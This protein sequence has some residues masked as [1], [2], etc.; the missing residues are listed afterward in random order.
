VPSEIGT[1]AHLTQLFLQS[2]RLQG[3]LP[4][5]IGAVGAAS[6][7]KKDSASRSYPYTTS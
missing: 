7:S 4:S 5:Q 3:S 2:N 1:L 6:A